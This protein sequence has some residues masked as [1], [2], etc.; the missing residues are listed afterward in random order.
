MHSKITLI[1][2]C[3]QVWYNVSPPEQQKHGEKLWSTESRA[4]ASAATRDEITQRCFEV[5]LL[6]AFQQNRRGIL[7]WVC[8]NLAPTYGVGEEEPQEKAGPGSRESPGG[9][10]VLWVLRRVLCH[11]KATRVLGT[12]TKSRAGRSP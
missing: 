5:S 10:R 2:C 8:W 3:R 1:G 9:T 4:R 11:G 12:E 6:C 7:G